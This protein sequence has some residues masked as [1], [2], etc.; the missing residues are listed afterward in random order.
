[1]QRA[2]EQTI[3]C[4]Y[5]ATANDPPPPPGIRHAAVRRITPP[6]AGR[7]TEPVGH[8]ALSAL[9]TLA[10]GLLSIRQIRWEPESRGRGMHRPPNAVWAVFNQ[11]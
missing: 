4:T 3:E 5:A 2:N 9:A 1:M 6:A 7:S 8:S 11:A 10:H